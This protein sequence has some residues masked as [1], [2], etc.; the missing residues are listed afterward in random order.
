MPYVQQLTVQPQ[1]GP[2]ISSPGVAVRLHVPLSEFCAHYP[3]SSVDEKNLQ[4]VI[5][6]QPG[7]ELVENL[8]EKTWGKG[9]NGAQFG[10]LGWNMFLV[11]HWKFCNDAKAGLWLK[12]NVLLFIFS[13]FIS[14]CNSAAIMLLQLILSHFRY[15]SLSFLCSVFAFLILSIV[16]AI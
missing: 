10:E 12:E 5:E 1:N 14:Y 6:Y 8:S 13:D 2:L 3:I 16:M 9:E 7:N 15:I 4:D 11:A